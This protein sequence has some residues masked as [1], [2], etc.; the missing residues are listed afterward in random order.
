[1]ASFDGNILE[2]EIEKHIESQMAE[3][4]NQAP[5]SDLVMT[6]NGVVN[7]ALYDVMRGLVDAGT[8]ELYVTGGVLTF[9][10]L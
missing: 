6:M 5:V 3:S 10:K 4:G 7:S 1:M 8:H 2:G 9:K